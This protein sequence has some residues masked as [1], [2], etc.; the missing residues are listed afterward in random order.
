MSDYAFTGTLQAFIDGL[1]H[2]AAGAERPASER[3]VLINATRDMLGRLSPPPDAPGEAFFPDAVFRPG[4]SVAGVFTVVSL[5]NRGGLGEIYRA[6]HKDLGTDHA[7]K[8]LR[9]GRNVD[10][11]AASLFRNE[12]RLLTMVRNDAVVGGQGLLR[13]G[14]GRMV[15]V[16]DFL[17]GPNLARVLRNGAMSLPDVL[18]LGQRLCTGLAAMHARAI[19]HQDLSPANIVLCDQ[20]PAGATLV[21]FGVARLLTETRGVHETLDFAGKYTWAAPEQLD[22]LAS[23]DTRSDLYSLGL[24]LAA[25]VSGEPLWMGEDEVVGRRQRAR[26][27]AL[28]TVPPP[29]RPLLSR[30]LQPALAARPATAQDVLTTLSDIQPAKP[31]GLFKRSAI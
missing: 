7:L 15:I 26:V 20:E 24:V 3:E 12:A 21:D 22:P 30:L 16:M 27:P 31:R 10:Q 9:A 1:V 14:D 6:R 2:D 11:H 13:D 28:D 4:Q 18:A 23:P 29:L 8:V 5:V 19:I 17:R 25:A